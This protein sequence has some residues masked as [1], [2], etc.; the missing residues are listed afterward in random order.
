MK[1]QHL[2]A[3][4]GLLVA[5][6]TVGYLALP[7]HSQAADAPAALRPAA[8]RV[9]VAPVEQR[10]VTEY[11]ELTGRVEARETVELRA[12]VS[13]HLEA[14]SFQAGQ[15]VNK[16]DLL[17]SID[18]R[19]HQA[20]FDLAE[21]RARLAESEASRADELLQASAISTEEA[22][23]RRAE[24]AAARAQLATARLDLEHTQVLA[25][26]S[27]RVS[28]AL[29]TQGNL[30]SGSAGGGSLLT[31]IVS[32]GDSYVYADLDEATLLRFNRL[33]RENRLPATN[34]HIAA[35][36]QLADEE[37]YPRHGYIESADNRVN[38]ST[39][40]LAI[41]FLFPNTDKALMP[42]LFARVRIPVSAPEAALLVSERAIGTDQSQK[43]VLAVDANHTV[44]YRPVKLGA[45]LDGK[46]VIR[47]GL[48]PGDRIIVNGLQRVRP[49]MTVDPEVQQLAD[50]APEMVAGPGS[51]LATLH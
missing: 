19:W 10:L 45:N 18:P 50:S 34:G 1:T 32:D 3:A 42:G 25:P 4:T 38:P 36:L 20:Q 44:T 8:P 37:G 5:A 6:G 24:A 15:H 9:T 33:V 14:V 40:S 43:F 35:E 16:G 28:R 47:E 12:R 2:L 30:V 13:G 51:K 7:S 11:E 22:E 29:V 46:R 49:G 23:R 31:T 21:A 26:I 17:F 27:G 48:Q 41:R 39:G